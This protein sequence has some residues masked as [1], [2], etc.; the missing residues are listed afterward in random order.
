MYPVQDWDFSYAA[1]YARQT[2]QNRMRWRGSDGTELLCREI[3]SGTGG[4]GPCAYVKGEHPDRKNHL[5]VRCAIQVVDDVAYLYPPDDVEA[6]PYE[7]VEELPD[8]HNRIC[9]AVGA[10][11]FRWRDERTGSLRMVEGVKGWINANWLDGG[12]HIFHDGPAHLDAEGY[13]RMLA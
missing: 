5:L 3:V 10:E 12:S 9:A 11:K 2:G 7:V 8:T 13:V 6:E 4:E 1:S